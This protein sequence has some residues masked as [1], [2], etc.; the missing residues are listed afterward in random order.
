MA[1]PTFSVGRDVQAVL[2]A[3][4]GSRFDLSNVTD[5]DWKPDYATV[6]VDPVTGPTLERFL[7]KGHRITYSVQRKDA[8]NDK[9][10][11]AIEQGW[12]ASGSADAGTGIAGSAFFYIIEASGATSTYQFLGVSIKMTEGGMFKQDAAIAQKFEAFAQT[13]SIT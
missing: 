8:T 6:K 11:A 7:P 5:F 10:I 1:T 9:L 2:V 12:W 13:V 4:N 3:S